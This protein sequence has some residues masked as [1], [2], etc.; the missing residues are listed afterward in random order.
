MGGSVAV[1]ITLQLLNTNP[2]LVVPPGVSVRCVA[3]APAPV[4]RSQASFPKKLLEKIYIY[5]Y[6]KDVVPS[7]SLGSVA[8]LLAMLRKVDGLEL[9][10]AE[11]LRIVLRK[12]DAL[13][14]VNKERVR[15]AVAEAKQH[16]FP[17]LHHIG[18]VTQLVKKGNRVEVRPRELKDAK[19]MA[20]NIEINDTM[21]MDH[22]PTEYKEIFTKMVSG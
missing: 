16:R 6:G 7:L 9:S 20:A 2:H 8:R 21:L 15:L 14:Q 3:L 12:K 22:I 18:Q 10:V 4:Y 19:E 11:Q 17:Y 5:I 1:L 13:A